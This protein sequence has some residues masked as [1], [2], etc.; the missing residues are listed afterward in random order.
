MRFLPNGLAVPCMCCIQG[1]IG[2]SRSPR[3]GYET[4]KWLLVPTLSLAMSGGSSSAETLMRPVPIRVALIG[5]TAVVIH[6]DGQSDTVPCADLNVGRAAYFTSA[7]VLVKRALDDI[8]DQAVAQ[9]LQAVRPRIAA[10][11][12]VALLCERAGELPSDPKTDRLERRL[13]RAIRKFD[14][15]ATRNAT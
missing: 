7:L 2:K 8:G 12:E 15:M 1:A 14:E 13:D 10:Y 4:M 3:G 6:R 9:D 5:S 11:N